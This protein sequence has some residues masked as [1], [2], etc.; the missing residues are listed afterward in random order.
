MPRGKASVQLYDTRSQN[1]AP[2][3]VHGNNC[4]SEEVKRDCALEAAEETEL[5][6]Q[7]VDQL[8]MA[9]DELLNAPMP[10]HLQK[11]LTNLLDREDKS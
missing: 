1:A 8:R 4:A 7:I 9:Y 10:D 11:L 2:I 6:E 3:A 5:S